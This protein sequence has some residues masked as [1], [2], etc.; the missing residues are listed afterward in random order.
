MVEVLDAS[1]PTTSR[2]DTVVIRRIGVAD[3]RDSLRQGWSDFAANPTQLVFLSIIYPVIG[4]ISARAGAGYDLFVPLVF[5]LITGV[6]LLGPVLAV[7]IYEL[8][9]RRERGLPVSWVNAF[10]VLRSPA[11]P[12]IVLVGLMLLAIFSAWLLLAK[13]VFDQTVGLAQPASISE[14]V[15]TVFHTANGWQ[16]ILWGNLIGLAIA[17]V[18][19][20]LTVVSVPMLLDRTETS[21]M[22]AIGTS[23]R[24]VIANPGTM[25]LWGVLV[26]AILVLG[27]LPLFIGLAITMPVLSHATWHLYRKLVT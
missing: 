9:R 10:D 7:G 18:V 8:S 3:L 5:P 14:F 19:L 1:N 23:L 21:A 2:R 26:A 6:S 13:A 27:C 25:A 4:L 15:Q 12:A 20:A 22:S 16:M 17:V 24:A 11:L